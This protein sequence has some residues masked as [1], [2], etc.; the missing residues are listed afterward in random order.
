M[1]KSALS[2][3]H[4]MQGTVMYR[5]LSMLCLTV[6]AFGYATPLPAPTPPE[7][8]VLMAARTGQNP[9]DPKLDEW[10]KT[11]ADAPGIL[12][13]KPAE[14]QQK[15]KNLDPVSKA[16][17]TLR[18][19]RTGQIKNPAAAQALVE[20]RA[21]VESSD[22][23][24]KRHLLYPYLVDEWLRNIKPEE[25]DLKLTQ[26]IMKQYGEKSCVQRKTL[27]REIDLVKP[28]T[29]ELARQHLTQIGTFASRNF[30]QEALRNLLRNMDQE[31]HGELAADLQVQMKSFPRL[32]SEFKWVDALLD[33]KKE[34]QQKGEPFSSLD[35]VKDVALE[36]NCQVSHN[37]LVE[38]LPK[39][40][41]KLVHLKDV[42][43]SVLKVEGCYRARSSKERLKFWKDIEEPLTK[44][45]G[46]AG[47]EL[48]L[49]RRGLLLWGSDNFDEARLVFKKILDDA[50]KDKQK[51]ME[52]R[53]VYTFAR[54]EENAGNLD[55]AISYYEEFVNQFRD[56]KIYEAEHMENALTSLVIL[57]SVSNQPQKA[58]T[59]AE[60][61]IEEESVK[62]IDLR[63]TSGLSFA[64]YWA[65]RLNYEIGN[66]QKAQ[67][68]WRRSASE[69]YSSFYGA[70]AHF[71]LE[72]L[73]GKALVLQPVRSIPFNAPE[74]YRSFSDKL[75][76]RSVERAIALLGHGLRDEASC[77]I[78]EL[79]VGKDENQKAYLKSLLLYA[80]GDWFEA[81]RIYGNLPR[82]LR[83]TLPAGS[84]RMLFP[85]AYTESVLHYSEK[86]GV[87]PDYVLAII[88]Q[89]S[90]FNPKA[91]SPVGAQGLMQLM[92]ATAKMEAKKLRR[93]YVTGQTRQSINAGLAA[94][95]IYDPE[96]NLALGV[97]H[98][99]RLMSTYK[100]PIFV[101]TAYNASPRATERWRKNIPTDDVL[102]FMERIPYRETRAYV[103]LVL[104]NYFYYKRWYNSPNE[105][106]AH[107]ELLTT[108]MEE[109]KKDQTMRNV[110][111]SL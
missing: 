102:A 2:L 68:Y 89:E 75:E 45:F 93:D 43:T 72:K 22:E 21:V 50:K 69:F 60:R 71:S 28:L 9:V 70:I 81:I 30:R 10:L 13:A 62:D 104:R 96:T 106:L 80:A 29:V 88:R 92:P 16:Y 103:K 17:L 51:A 27:L 109:K 37:L 6:C 25:K 35:K 11:Y 5:R 107:L 14:F 49:R 47:E 66:T 7:S 91:R 15:V 23:T 101:L 18:Y 90:V 53:T 58:L 56:P 52:A 74:L 98:V 26:D 1:K 48:A 57:Y 39:T 54:I 3:P 108:K 20:A 59:Y 33:G 73:V 110:D 67:E 77:E 63:S 86:L 100:S 111:Y 32:R 34:K 79:A 55:A 94:Q 84:E 87:D 61:M 24:L 12:D 46:F 38:A 97:H 8:Y 76:Q 4:A 41:G 64:L 44:T 65:G 95:K 78:S 42:E 83:N 105:K 99:H 19:A 36:K 31:E 40:E 82:S 85:K